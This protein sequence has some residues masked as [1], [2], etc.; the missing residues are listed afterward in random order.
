MNTLIDGV[1]RIQHEPKMEKSIHQ[2]HVIY[3][4]AYGGTSSPTQ[5]GTIGNHLLNRFSESYFLLIL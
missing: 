2:E 3:N 1:I 4:A 5:A